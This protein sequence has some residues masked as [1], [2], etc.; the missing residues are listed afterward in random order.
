MA[1]SKVLASACVFSA[2]L[3]V[4]AVGGAENSSDRAPRRKAVQSSVEG[5]SH[6]DGPKLEAS[7]NY[8]LAL[9][10]KD[11]AE[12]G[13]K[14]GT[15]P[16]ERPA[17]EKPSPDKVATDKAVTDKPAAEKS[18][19]AKSPSDK[20][21]ASKDDRPRLPRYYGQLGLS[22]AQREKI[23]GIQRRHAENITKLQK[24]LSDA[25]ALRETETQQV[26]TPEQKQKLLTSSEAGKAAAA[27]NNEEE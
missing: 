4:T 5:M 10:Q 9:A 12:T 16:A 26:L 27:R 8:S 2:A 21:S 17:V 19:A 23:Y 6:A 1:F 11:A 7:Q 24:Q 14:A 18:V 22:D 3:A 13:K 15:R 20:V 25:K